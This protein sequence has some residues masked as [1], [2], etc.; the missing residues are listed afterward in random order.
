MLNRS[1]RWLLLSFVLVAL[2]I[3]PATAQSKTLYWD[4]FDV[5]ITVNDD[6]SFDVVELQDIE[7]TSGSFTFGS[8]SIPTDLVT[9]IRDIKVW[10]EQGEYTQSNSQAPGTFSV[11]DDGSTVTIRWY[12]EEA[13]DENRAFSIGYTVDGGVRYYD[14]D[15]QIWWKAVYPDRSFPAN[16][17][18]VIVHVPAPAEVQN[19]DSY[20]TTSEMTLLDP[21]TSQFVATE[22]ISP[23]QTFEVRVE[24]TPGVVA[25]APAPWQQSEDAR[26]VELES[27]VAF[28]RNWRPIINL[29]VG[30]FSLLFVVL[31]PLLLYLIWYTRGRDAEADFVAEYLPE[32]PSDMPPGMVGTLLDEKA[33]MEDIL[34]TLVDLGHKGY[35]RMEE[36]EPKKK[37]LF[38]RGEADFSYTLEKQADGQLRTYERQLITSLFG[39]SKTERKLSDLK[40][41]FYKHLPKIRSELYEEVVEEGLFVSHPEKT[42]S[43]WV[44]LGIA[45]LLAAV[46]FGCTIN[47]VLVSFSDFAL[48][49][50]LGFGL[51]AFGMIFLARWMPRK[52]QEGAEQAARWQAF[53][54]YLEDIDTYTD[55]E[56][57]TELFDRYLP[58]A[59]AFGLESKYIKKWSKVESAPIPGW[60]IP[61]PRPIY[62]SY[63]MPGYGGSVAGGGAPSS[64]SPETGGGMPSLGDASG[65]MSAGLAGMSAGLTTMLSSASSTMA[66]RPQPSG[67]SGGGGWSGGG[68]SGGGSFGGGGGGGGGGGFG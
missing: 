27:Q 60:Y 68:F 33:D 7:F 59:I 13:Q 66:S 38:G 56:R 67:G 49:L 64:S 14:G 36:L 34:A 23:G 25:G 1:F 31:A 39:S 37:G 53:R 46:V 20:F 45:A 43:R 17:S 22:R 11:D 55:L 58:Y 40:T 12:F 3:V 63:G 16:N 47:I 8:R 21:Q 19:M 28:D 50:P 52:T 4:H 41:K 42:R 30:A 44:I 2:L 51:F 6:G 32:P 15:D 5:D 65:G 10:D 26:A 54:T 61:Y 9:G 57:A 24:F 62:G 29:I 48:C 35:I 18:T